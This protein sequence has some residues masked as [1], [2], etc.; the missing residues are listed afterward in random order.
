MECLSSTA[1]TRDPARTVL[2]A[3][4]PMRILVADDSPKAARHCLIACKA[5]RS[6]QEVELINHEFALLEF[7]VVKSRQPISKTVILE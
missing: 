5:W 6:G 4:P 3:K 7:F 1:F 2:T